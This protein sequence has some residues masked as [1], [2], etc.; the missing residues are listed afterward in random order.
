MNQIDRQIALDKSVKYLNRW[1][2][3]INT[4]DPH[5]EI[6]K[7]VKEELDYEFSDFGGFDVENPKDGQVLAYDSKTGNWVN[8]DSESSLPVP[9]SSDEGKLLS[10]DSNGEYTLVEIDDSEN[11]KY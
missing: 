7:I 1:N 6:N 2:D 3:Y 10:V 11:I 5:G 9:T 4:I 8:K